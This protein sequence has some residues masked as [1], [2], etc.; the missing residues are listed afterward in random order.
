[1]NAVHPALSGD[2]DE[3][4]DVEIRA[5]RLA[6]LRRTDQEG[7]VSLEAMQGKAV[8]LAVDRD[9]PEPE[10]GGG[11]EASNG[12]FRSVGN[13]E[14]THDINADTVAAPVHPRILDGPEHAGARQD[15]AALSSE[16]RV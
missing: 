14:L 15:R 9:R 5:D 4:T 10:L 6:A 7:F 13:Q 8:L 2:G 16:R 11:A 3:R 12:D 1:M